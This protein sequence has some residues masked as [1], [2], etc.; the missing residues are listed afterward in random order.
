[1]VDRTLEYELNQLIRLM[2]DS[3]EG[4]AKAAELTLT[5][6]YRALFTRLGER[7]AKFIEELSSLENVVGGDPV[8]EGALGAALYRTLK[9]LNV[10]V[11]S[12]KDKV[13][14]N[15]VRDV[16]GNTIQRY[17]TILADQLSIMSGVVKD[18]IENQHRELLE[19][20]THINSLIDKYTSD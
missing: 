2:H 17:E 7:R 10:S 12:D 15:A 4:Y 3:V 9:E 20:Q 18:T 6:E 13:I 1:M 8:E 19:T 16:L 5:E 11:S 14:L